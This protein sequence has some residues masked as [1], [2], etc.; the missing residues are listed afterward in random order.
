MCFKR[1]KSVFDTWILFYLLSVV[2]CI[3]RIY[4]QFLRAD[5]LLLLQ[6]YFADIT[7]K[8]L[9]DLLQQPSFIDG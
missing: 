8:S 7:V 5:F 3:L 1:L 2:Q 9:Q 6:M 4:W